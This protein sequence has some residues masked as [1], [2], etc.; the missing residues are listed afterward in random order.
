[1]DE[2]QENAG[3]VL[4]YLVSA[5]SYAKTNTQI[6]KNLVQEKG[7]K[8]IYITIN[9]PYQNLIE[10]FS[11]KGIDTDKIFFIDAITKVTGGKE[12]DVKNCVFLDSP[13]N[14]TDIAIAMRQAVNFM[15][16]EKFIFVDAIST[17]L[18]YNN[19]QSVIKFAHFI[20]GRIRDWKA[21]GIIISILKDMD[22]K[23]KSQ[24]T[25]F[26]DSK[27]EVSQ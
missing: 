10:M 16:G 19:D 13:T 26:C 21:E 6:I 7:L 1:M 3:N 12:V 8:G 15:E 24:L 2:V 9:R 14:L 11:R 22:E 5:E 25:E 23:L 18:I 20:I 27:I 4:L 17:L